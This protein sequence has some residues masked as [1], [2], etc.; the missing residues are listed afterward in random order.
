MGVTGKIM[1]NCESATALVEKERDKQ[2]DFLER[3]GLWIHLGYCGLCKLFFK[4]S[5]IL[6]DSAKAYSEKVTHEQKAYKL[7]PDR[8]ARLNKAFDVELKNQN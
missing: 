2:L 6:D 3:I 7:D 1:M 8:K 4:Q 5:R